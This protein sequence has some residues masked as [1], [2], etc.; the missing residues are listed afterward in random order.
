VHNL[1]AT[2]GLG[3]GD[4]AVS[5]KNFLGKN[6]QIWVNLIGFGRNSSKFEAKFGQK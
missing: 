6:D 5:L 4:A 3:A 1:A 2:S